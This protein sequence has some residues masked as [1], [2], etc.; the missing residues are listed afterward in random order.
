MVMSR[1]LVYAPAA[2]V[3]RTVGGTMAVGAWRPAIAAVPLQYPGVPGV[4]RA[5][6]ER[7]HARMLHIPPTLSPDLNRI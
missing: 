5:T 6:R 7:I 3:T 1:T 2:I 4:G